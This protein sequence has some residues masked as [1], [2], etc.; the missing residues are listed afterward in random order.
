ML[1][2]L[3]VFFSGAG[4]IA[5]Y[6]AFEGLAQV[7]EGLKNW[8]PGTLFNLLATATWT[9]VPVFLIL[10]LILPIW[11]LGTVATYYATRVRVEGYDIDLLAAEVAQQ[12][13]RA[14]FEI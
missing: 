11:S 13:K 1:L 7:S 4:T 14:R 3:V 5:A 9:L 10:W 2:S 12:D 6:A 8:M